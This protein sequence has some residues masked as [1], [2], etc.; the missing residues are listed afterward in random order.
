MQDIQ[1]NIDYGWSKPETFAHKYL[2]SSI[3]KALKWTRTGNDAYI[4]DAGCGGA[5]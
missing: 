4:L 3:L 5:I 1:N 2:L